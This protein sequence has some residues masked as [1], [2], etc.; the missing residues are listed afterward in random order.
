MRCLTISQQ[1]LSI[2]ASTSTTTTGVLKRALEGQNH[3]A[4]YKQAKYYLS[5]AVSQNLVLHTAQ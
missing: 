4:L 5:D 3:I 1:L 2:A